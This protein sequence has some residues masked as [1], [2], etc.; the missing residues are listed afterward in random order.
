[1]DGARFDHLTAHLGSRL[2]RR[3]LAGLV[4]ALSL[5]L[6]ATG[7]TARKKK[8]KK[9]KRKCGRRCVAVQTDPAN[10]GS[11]RRACAAGEIC[12]EGTCRPRCP[13]GQKACDGKC[14]PA[15]GCC[16]SAECADAEE[17]TE[18]VCLDN[19]CRQFSRDDNTSCVGGECRSGVCKNCVARRGSCT[20]DDQCC[21]VRTNVIVCALNL[22]S[23]LVSCSTNTP[24]CCGA[25]GAQ[26][27]FDC[28]CCEGR[29]CQG[30]VCCNS[31]GI[32]CNQGTDCCSGNCVSSACA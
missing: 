24:R 10:C 13:A 26:C 25:V 21:G 9:P 12:S 2:P 6:P 8:C 20:T 1:M 23:G 29:E 22:H 11:C 5:S 17:C 16:E 14:I 18:D 7:A 4:G 30:N 32:F 15:G 28:D 3:S 31:I 19:V 27:A